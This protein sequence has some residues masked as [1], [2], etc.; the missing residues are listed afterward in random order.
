MSSI[1]LYCQLI[2][3]IILNLVVPFYSI[4]HTSIPNPFPPP[5][6]PEGNRTAV[7]L[8]GQL[9]VGNVSI[10]SPNVVGYLKTNIRKFF[11]SD[12]PPTPIAT[13]LEHFI[14]ILAR[15]GGVDLFIYF[16]AAHRDGSIDNWNGDPET[17]E[18]PIVVYPCQILQLPW[19]YYSLSRETPGHVSSIVQVQ[20]LPSPQEIVFSV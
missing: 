6:Y 7:I 15:H 3:C 4:F 11:G 9:R 10:L 5:K 17:Y 18:V 2:V 12:D 13:H 1:I 20:Y 8:S 14:Q 16:E 19:Y